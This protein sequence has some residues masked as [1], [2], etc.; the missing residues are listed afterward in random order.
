MRTADSFNKLA[1]AHEQTYY[2][3]AAL[4]LAKAENHQLQANIALARLLGLD[5]TTAFTLPARLPDLPK[6]SKSLKTVN[7]DNFAKR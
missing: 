5:D 2:S 7:S 1:L 6:S 3:E 4:D